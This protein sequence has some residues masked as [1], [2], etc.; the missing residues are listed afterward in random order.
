MDIEN[1]ILK[2][3]IEALLVADISPIPDADFLLKRIS[4]RIEIKQLVDK[5]SVQLNS[6]PEVEF[7]SPVCFAKS[8][9]VQAEYLS[10]EETMRLIDDYID[11]FI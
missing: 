6:S 1:D 8:S 4:G 3:L 7:A 9:E 10:E 11:Q 2:K 5:K